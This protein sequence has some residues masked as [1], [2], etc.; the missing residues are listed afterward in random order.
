[1]E[2]VEG[3]VPVIIDGGIRLGTDVVKA[4]ALGADFVFMGRPALWGLAVQGQKGVEDVLS[5]IRNELETDMM[6]CGAASVG[7]ITRDLVVH[8]SHYEEKLKSYL[9]KK[10][11]GSVNKSG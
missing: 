4:L 10:G 8:E 2:A 5:I 11:R 9:L 1:M 3:R 7:E 6:L